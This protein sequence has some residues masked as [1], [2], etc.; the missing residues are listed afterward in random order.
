MVSRSG[1][2]RAGQGFQIGNSFLTAVKWSYVMDGGRQVTTTLVTFVLAR[3]LG[4]ETFGVAA[5]ALVLIFFV[6]MIQAQG[7]VA[8]IVQREELR[9]SHLQSAFWM[10]VVLSVVL[11][12]LIIV[13]SAPYA[14][15]N[16]TREVVPVVRWMSLIVPFYGLTLVQE[17]LLRRSMNFKALALRTNLS[18]F[19]AGFVAIVLVYFGAGVWALVV[20]H[21]LSSL[22]GMVVLWAVGEW[23]PR[24]TFSVEALRDLLGFSI[25]SL[26]AGFAVFVNNRA[27]ALLIGVFFGPL[28]VGL[29]RFALRL[30]ETLV[31]LTTRAL[32]NV[33]LPALAQEF[34]RGA[35][36]AEVGDRALSVVGLSA[37]LS[38][39]LLGVLA[40]TADEVVALLGDE[41]W[42]PSVPVLRVLCV[43]GGV[44][45]VALVSG[46]LMQAVGRPGLFALVSWFGAVVGSLFLTGTGVLLGG[47]S[48]DVQ[49][50][51]I[52]I[53]RAVFAVVV[54]LS[55]AVLVTR[56]LV[57]TTVWQWFGVVVPSAVAA[58]LAFVVG[59]GLSVAVAGMHLLG[60]LFLVGS[61]SMVTAIVATVVLSAEARRLVVAG[62]AGAGSR[63]RGAGM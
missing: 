50:Y 11:M 48:P 16:G 63:L 27:D 33:A 32:Q 9:D 41:R 51:G 14:A 38:L 45:T 61:M 52:A 13:A 6:R 57:G 22:I 25:P 23:R 28:A 58:L 44:R 46:P 24:W 39:P 42:D 4:P 37:L 55:L 3:A 2:P 49:V 29:Y 40:A 30:V 62:L 18:V 7:I 53:S 31:E 15:L 56:S 43:A 21:V 8:A 47:A 5:L 34:R 59:E 10:Q 36:R 60:R 54:V 26:F 1:H 12:A 20:Q 35:S 19:V 17:A